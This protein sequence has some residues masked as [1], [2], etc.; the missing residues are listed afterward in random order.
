M[1]CLRCGVCCQLFLVNLTEEEY[2]SRRYKTAFDEFV[3]DFALA[4]SSG[5]NTLEQ[6]EDG[7]CVYLMDDVC[8]IHGDRPAS[9]R[10]FFCTGQEAA[11]SAMRD[12]IGEFRRRAG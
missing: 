3:G 11:F 10:A 12:E 7:S 8:T 1:K 9:C 6:R 4:E 5:A 2:R